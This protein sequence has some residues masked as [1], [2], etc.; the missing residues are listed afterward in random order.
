MAAKASP[1][2]SGGSE[3][4]RKVVEERE[5]IKMWISRQLSSRKQNKG[6]L[7]HFVKFSSSIIL[8][9][10]FYSYLHLFVLLLRC[11]K[12]RGVYL[13]STVPW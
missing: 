3:G 9:R 8:K 4:G 10:C 11:F 2:K 5:K 13:W 12:I 6:S 7:N 1:Q